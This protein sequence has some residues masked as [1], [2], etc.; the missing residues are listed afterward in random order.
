MS[1]AIPIASVVAVGAVT[2]KYKSKLHAM[3]QSQAEALDDETAAAEA[4]EN[5][6]LL[7]NGVAHSLSDLKR[8]RSYNDR[9]AKDRVH[10][11]LP[12]PRRLGAYKDPGIA[13][14]V[15][16]NQRPHEYK[17]GRYDWSKLTSHSRAPRKLTRIGPYEGVPQLLLAYKR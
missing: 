7:G 11:I 5:R 8:V 12:P 3:M 13:G 6:P 2:Y 17:D 9:S 16:D 15:A 1:L 4:R 10:N 14:M